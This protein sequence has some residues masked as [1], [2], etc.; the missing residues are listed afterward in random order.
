LGRALAANDLG[1]YAD[2][3]RQIGS[4]AHLLSRSMLLMDKHSGLRRRA[5]RGFARHPGLFARLLAV[6]VGELPLARFG[7]NGILN[8]G[9]R[10]LTA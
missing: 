4:L 7:F 3:H 1:L 10:L 2:A 9:W 8:L 5:L 6:H